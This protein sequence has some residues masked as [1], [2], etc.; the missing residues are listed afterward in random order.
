MPWY[1]GSVHCTVY[2]GFVHGRKCFFIEPHSPDQFF[3]RG[4]LRLAGRRGR[5]A[6]FWRA[7][8][9]FMLK[10]GKR[11]EVIHC[12][13]WQTALCPSRCTRSTSTSAWATS[14]SAIR[15]TTSAPGHLR[16]VGLAGH[17]LT[18]PRHFF[19]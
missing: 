12:H 7:A 4:H 17:R 14:G 5:F 2:F 8:L 13:D 10:S 9:E 3:N 1:S 19:D 15:C 16:R 18:S 6:F 11:P